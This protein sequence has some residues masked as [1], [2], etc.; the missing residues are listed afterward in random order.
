MQTGDG[1][2]SEDGELEGSIGSALYSKLRAKKTFFK[3]GMNKIIDKTLIWLF[4]IDSVV[5][6]DRVLI[7]SGIN[8]I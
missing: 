8:E 1:E 5:S 7:R 6:I 2:G 4:S 3:L